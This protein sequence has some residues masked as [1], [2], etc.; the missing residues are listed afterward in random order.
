MLGSCPMYSEICPVTS[1]LKKVEVSLQKNDLPAAQ[2]SAKKLSEQ[3]ER[4]MPD[5]SEL[6][7]E[8]VKSRNL[9]QARE[10]LQALQ[11]KMLS[12]AYNPHRK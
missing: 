11:K 1:T 12:D 7:D 6:S 5:L 4:T 10:K 9:N 2:E 8:I 3:L